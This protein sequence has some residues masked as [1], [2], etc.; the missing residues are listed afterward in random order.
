M[1]S[2]PAGDSD[3]GSASPAA[4]RRPMNPAELKIELLCRGLRIDGSCRIFEDGRPLVRTRAGLGSGLELIVPGTK[5]DV[6]VNAPVVEKFVEATPYRLLLDQ[7][8]YKIVD[9]K[10]LFRYRVKL[11]SKPEWYDQLTSRGIPMS[12]V[13]TLQGTCLSIYIGARCKFWSVE[14]P[15]NC[16]F[17]T[18]GR[19]IGVDEEEEKTVE[20]VVETAIAAKAESDVAFIHFNSGYQGIK[21]LRKAF[22]YLR[23]L[24]QRVGCLIGVQF[25]P[26]GD[27]SLYDEALAL[28]VDHFSFCF[29]FYNP[30]YFR[31]YLPGKT[32][33]LGREVFFRAM[34]YCSRKMG[35]GRVSG[36]II[37]GI[38]PL[39]D[40]LRAIEY[41]VRVGAFP[42][43]C[44]FR[45]LAGGDMED[46]PPPD[47]SEMIRVFRHVY[48]TCRVHNLP[49]GIAPNINV[50]LSLQPD[51]TFYLA[52]G[53]VADK[54]YQSWVGA[55]KH[56][57][58][59][60][61]SRRMRPQV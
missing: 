19:N 55:L 25:I 49:V 44:I 20:D 33:V 2:L 35:K 60:Y 57:M 8:E 41:I 4:P 47:P 21:G 54:M 30:E 29:E 10:R 12:C 42:F 36:E 32:E 22:P 50:S 51:D 6:W 43:V 13:G 9:E 52:S 61:F 15:M 17:C 38:E 46:Y 45:P 40:T 34:E 31:H 27:L 59:P 56:L 58:R 28:G 24:K 37:A 14:H 39:E 26:E 5:R 11:A 48:E 7:G 1:S 16:R 23:A 18:A 3:T 53:G